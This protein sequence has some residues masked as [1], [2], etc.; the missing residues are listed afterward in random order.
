MERMFEDLLTALQQQQVLIE[1]L[2]QKLR[3]L[4]IGGGGGNA[5]IADYVSGTTYQHNSLVHDTV[6][7]DLYLVIAETSYVAI[8]ISTDVGNGNLKAVGGSGV[9]NLVLFDHD[10]T[11]QEI[12]GLDENTA[13]IV[14]SPSDDPFDPSE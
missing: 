2:Y 10:P 9:S 13:V 1:N 14:Y 11:Q 8:D 12:E 6:T 4:E 5:T 3:R 7:D